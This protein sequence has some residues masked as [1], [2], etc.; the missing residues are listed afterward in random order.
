MQNPTDQAEASIPTAANVTD[1]VP[2]WN[3]IVNVRR[4]AAKR[5]HPFDLTEEELNLVPQEEDEDIPARKKPRLEEPFPTTTDEAT[6]DAASPDVSEGLN[7]HAA[8]NDGA[9]LDAD[10][11][12][13][14]QPNAGATGRWALEEDAKLTRAVANT[15]KKKCGKEYKTDWVTISVLVPGR[16]KSQCRM[17]W[18]KVQNYSIDRASEP[19]GCRWTAVEDSKLKDAVQTHG[20]KDWGE[21]AA[22]VPGRTKHQCLDRW[23]KYMDPSLG[24]LNGQTGKWAA[25]ED[26]KLKDA[27]QAHGEKEWGAISLMVPGRTKNQCCDRWHSGLNPSIALTGGKWEEDEDSKLKDAVQTHGDKDWGA[28]SALVPGR[29]R[30][31]CNNRWHSTLNPSI[32]LTAGRKG[33]RWI[34]SEDS[35]LKDAVQTHGEKDWG[36]I[37]ALVPG[38]TLKQCWHRW[39]DALDP[40][41]GQASGRKFS[42]WTAAEDSKLKDAVQKTHG[43]KDWVAISLLVPG[44]TKK[45]CWNR[46]KHMDSSTVRG[47]E[48]SILKTAPCLGQDTHSR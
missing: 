14:T 37:S 34:A 29:T 47:T 11:V 48:H 28:I 33:S 7:P 32:T 42:R 1:N 19:K 22:L 24:R 40:T 41:I 36:A 6:R 45:Q 12:S 35:K 17:R 25:V 15:C 4:K 13:D 18:H 2:D 31:Q 16:T 3:R 21:I 20:D 39:H 23:N 46:W 38:R 5:T 8:E 27:V 26:S 9:N 44:R 43:D 30:I 10:R